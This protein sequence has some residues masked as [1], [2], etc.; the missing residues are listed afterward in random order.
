[1][2]RFQSERTLVIVTIVFDTV[3]TA[4]RARVYARTQSSGMCLHVRASG[5]FLLFFA[6]P[7]RPTRGQKSH[8]EKKNKNV[9]EILY[10]IT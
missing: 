7:D 9:G 2:L 5:F 4:E 3:D 8:R 1:M 6:D 10:G